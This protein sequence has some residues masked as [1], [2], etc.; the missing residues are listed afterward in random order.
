M[1]VSSIINEDT[2]KDYI[3][4]KARVGVDG[5]DKVSRGVSLCSLAVLRMMSPFLKMSEKTYAC[6]RIQ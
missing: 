1:V 4:T 3:I 5:S 6:W 2:D